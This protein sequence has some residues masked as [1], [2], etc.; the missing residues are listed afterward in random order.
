MRGL[1]AHIHFLAKNDAMEVGLARLP[2]N[3]R[4]PVG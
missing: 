3:Q 2:Q 4:P 1:A